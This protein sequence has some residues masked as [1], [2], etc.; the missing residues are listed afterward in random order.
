M[1]F[2]PSPRPALHKVW[3]KKK[4]VFWFFLSRGLVNFTLSG[5]HALVLGWDKLLDISVAANSAV[6]KRIKDVFGEERC[7]QLF[8][9]ERCSCLVGEE[10]FFR[11]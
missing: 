10:D 2:V 11:R 3:R 9:E 7:L 1:S 5:S 4:N 6:E 8:R